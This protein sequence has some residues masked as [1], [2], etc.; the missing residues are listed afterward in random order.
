MKAFLAVLLQPKNLAIM[1][2]LLLGIAI[3]IKALV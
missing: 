1:V 2:G 3:V